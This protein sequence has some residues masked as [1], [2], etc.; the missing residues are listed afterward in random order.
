MVKAFEVTASNHGRGILYIT[1]LGVAFES[2]KYGLVLDVSFEWLRSYAA[3]KNDK[4]EVVWDTPDGGRFRYTF[5]IESAA[6][7][8]NAYAAANN[9]YAESTSEIE[10]LRIMFCQRGAITRDS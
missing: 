1:S 7:A 5:K 8:V 2:I 10:H 6:L 3:P 4:F 9:Q